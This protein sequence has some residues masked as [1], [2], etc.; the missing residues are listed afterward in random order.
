[1]KAYVLAIDQGTT[2]SRSMVFDQQRRI[3]SL[4]QREHQQSYPR[5]GW[6]EHDA[7]QIWSTQS[8][9]I[10]D[11][12]KQA[13]LAPRD[14]S[15]IGLTNQRETT[16]VWDRG[17]GVPIGPAI[18]WQDRRTADR[19]AALLAQ[20]HGPL[21]SSRTGLLPDSYFSATKLEW[22][23]REVPGARA[24]AA[25]GELAFGTIDS[26]LIWNLSGGR[27]HVTDISNASRTML[28]NIHTGEWDEELLQLFDI[29]RGCLPRVLPCAF[30]TAA[31]PLCAELD[32]VSVPITGIAGDQQAALFGQA[33][34]S[35]G[36]AKNTYGTGCFLLMNT[37]TTVMQSR[38]HL[39]ATVAWRVGTDA[40]QYALEGSVFVGGAAVQ[41]L[42]D[43]L[44]LIEDSAAVEALA[45]RVPDSAGVHF[46]P[47]FTGLGAPYWDPQARGA[48]LGLTRGTSAAH[49]ARATLEAI[50]FQCTDVLKAMQADSGHP[51]HEL[52]V[53]GGGSRN[54]LLMQFQADLLGAPVVCAQHSESTALGAAC[55]AGVGAEIWSVA[56]VA[57]GWQSGATYV[58]RMSRDEAASRLQR[59]ALAVAST[60][61]F[62]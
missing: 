42:R 58:P 22:L 62:Q 52:R 37:G 53:D 59:W 36:M 33:C 27:T 32:G 48:L 10:A 20:G 30:S 13:G 49:I 40:P 34:L 16:V 50:A 54:A 24:R 26:W 23:L 47:A 19:C 15:A 51:L 39:L 8:A 41:W 29:P 3:I 6:V 60:R 17:S 45:R 56:E 21:I 14:L 11:A 9:T 28:F 46:V 7:A 55:L 38:Q 25:R 2:S 31:E 4:A 35:P 1:M 43:G 61:S 18:V 57:A 12:L 5:S 44:G